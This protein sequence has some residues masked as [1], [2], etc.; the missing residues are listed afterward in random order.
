MAETDCTHVKTKVEGREKYSDYHSL[1]STI[2][3]FSLGI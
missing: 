2:R 1:K 3:L